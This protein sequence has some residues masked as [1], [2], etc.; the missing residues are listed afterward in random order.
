MTSANF[1]H[2]VALCFG[3]NTGSVYHRLSIFSLAASGQSEKF[4]C[5]LLSLVNRLIDRLIA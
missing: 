2:R 4:S 3:S 5:R 1:W